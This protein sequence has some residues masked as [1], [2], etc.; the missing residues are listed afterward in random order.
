M[1]NVVKPQVAHREESIPEINGVRSRGLFRLS[2]SILNL[3]PAPMMRTCHSYCNY[4]FR[5]N[6]FAN[7]AAVKR[8]T[9]EDPMYPLAYL[10][11]EPEINEVTFTGADPL[12][13]DSR[14]LKEYLEPMVAS[15]QIER[16][17][18]STKAL[19]WWPYRFTE[20]EDAEGLLQLFDWVIQSGKVLNLRLHLV[21]PRELASEI[22]ERALV[23]IR[24]TGVQVWGQ[25]PLVKEVNDAPGTL[26]ELWH[27]SVEIGIM[28]GYL[29]L[30]TA[31][32]P[33]ACFELPIDQAWEIYCLARE[34]C[35]DLALQIP[36]P[37]YMGDVLHLYLIDQLEQAEEK[38][39]QMEV[40]RSPPGLELQNKRIWVPG[41]T[42]LQN[43]ENTFLAQLVEVSAPLP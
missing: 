31:R 39:F 18:I 33:R 29:F 25:G 26:A 15:A 42:S 21:H 1:V 12:V 32:H 9:Y 6:A 37:L 4:C 3:F 20:D 17:N 36:G 23:R 2:D 38:L 41:N 14:V 40:F 35:Q 22:V 24:Q 11:A 8:G 19:S 43:I 30:E 13:L 34:D 27:R 28:P 16:I 7:P 10:D 5:W